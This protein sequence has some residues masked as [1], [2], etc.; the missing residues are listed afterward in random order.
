MGFII[1]WMYFESGSL[2]P[3]LL[4]N[5]YTGLAGSQLLDPTWVGRT[6][7]TILQDSLMTLAPVLLIWLVLYLRKAFNAPPSRAPV[8]V[9]PAQAGS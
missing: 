1:G 5:S 3:C 2:W 7:P 9:E 6:A 4:M 8:L